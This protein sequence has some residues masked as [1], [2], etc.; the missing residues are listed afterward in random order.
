MQQAVS[1]HVVIGSRHYKVWLDTLDPFY[2]HRRSFR[3]C[4]AYQVEDSLR[5]FVRPTFGSCLTENEA[6]Q[7]CY[8]CESLQQEWK[9]RRGT[10]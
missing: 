2:P 6:V 9:E 7:A 1:S 4:R 10:L 3:W 8:S 5:G